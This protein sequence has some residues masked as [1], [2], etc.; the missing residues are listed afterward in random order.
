MK[1]HFGVEVHRQLHLST[2]ALVMFIYQM[3]SP[4]TANAG[5]WIEGRVT[6]VRDVDTIEVSN[7]A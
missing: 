2:I 6:H 1:V 7:P 5:E 4:I 3:A